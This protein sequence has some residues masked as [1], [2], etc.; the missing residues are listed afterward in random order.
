[1][2]L[3]RLKM[4]KSTFLDLYNYLKYFYAQYLNVKAIIAI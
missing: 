4:D 3:V 2:F 1:M